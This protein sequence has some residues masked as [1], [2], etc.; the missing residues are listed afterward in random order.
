MPARSTVDSGSRSTRVEEVLAQVGQHLLA[1]HERH[2][3]GPPRQQRL[4]D[5][6]RRE[7][8]ADLVDVGLGRAVLDRLD[9]HTQQPRPGQP[10]HRGEGVQDQHPGQRARVPGGQRAGVRPRL[11]SGGDGQRAPHGCR[12]CSCTVSEPNVDQ[13]ALAAGDHRPV[14]RVVAHER[15]VATHVDDDPAVDEGDLVALVE[16]Q[17]AGGHDDGRAAGARGCAGPARCAPRCA[18]R[19][20][21]SARR[22]RARRVGDQRAGQDEPLALAAGERPAALL[23]LG[24]QPVRERVED[25]VR[26]RDPHRV[27]QHARR[28]RP[29]G[30]A[31]R[32]RRAGCR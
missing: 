28:R 5:D 25:V 26:V 3:P 6:E 27:Q 4:R 1:E 9:Q 13:V 32:A 21:W 16:Q 10:G 2:R 15:A 30:R 19:P 29:S 7:Q 12:S 24:V 14:V 11:A 31:G 18:R 8:R 22:A 23:D 20:R 17:R